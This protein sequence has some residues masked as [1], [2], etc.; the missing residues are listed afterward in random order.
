MINVR[1]DVK[2]ANLLE[3]KKLSVEH[4]SEQGVVQEKVCDVSTTD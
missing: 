4:G 1:R 3:R 2:V